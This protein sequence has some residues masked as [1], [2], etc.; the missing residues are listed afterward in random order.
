MSEHF[1]DQLHPAT[2]KVLGMY[3][4]EQ[5]D[6]ILSFFGVMMNNFSTTFSHLYG[7]EPDEEFAKFACELTFD[8]AT[9]I[10]EH[11]K[12]QLSFGETWPP[13]IASLSVYKWKPLDREIRAARHALCVVK[14]PQ[15][16]VQKYIF[17][18][19]RGELRHIE[20]R[21]SDKA[22]EKLYIRA[23]QDVLDGYDVVSVQPQ[24]EDGDVV[25]SRTKM[26]LIVDDALANG[27]TQL[28]GRIGK[29]F[30]RI[31][32]VRRERNAD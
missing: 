23:Y 29:I 3:S 7:D 6:R 12:E 10:V 15:D 25:E 20:E 31:E 8:E 2:A 16:R 14:K 28:T 30:K 13:H 4:P 19:K 1:S 27:A 26:D 5:V 21:G 18:T 32:S 17:G 22:F 9:R 11:L 24:I